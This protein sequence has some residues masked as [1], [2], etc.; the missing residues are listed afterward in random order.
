MS[1]RYADRVEFEEALRELGFSV[2]EQRPS[3]GPRMYAARPNPFLTYWVHVYGDGT[4]LFTWEFAIAE[5]LAGKGLQ[6]G[7][8]EELNQFLYPRSDIRGAQDA[9]WLAEAIDHTESL[10]ASVRLADP[11]A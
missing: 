2:A 7:S 8:S 3:G 6:V 9:A 10:L 1:R 5:Y 11:E 4:A